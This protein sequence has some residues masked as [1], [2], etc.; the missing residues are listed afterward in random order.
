MFPYYSNKK[1]NAYYML[2][3]QDLVIQ[4][5]YEDVVLALSLLLL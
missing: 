1:I 5:G 3:T 4:K 2:G